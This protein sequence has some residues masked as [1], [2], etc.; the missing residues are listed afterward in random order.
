[1]RGKGRARRAALLAPYLGAI[2]VIDADGL[3]GEE[4]DFFGGEQF[5]QEQPALAI[6]MIDLRLS[7]FHGAFLRCFLFSLLMVRSASSRVSNHAGPDFAGGHPSRRGLRR[8][9][10]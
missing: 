5:G 2:G 10:G 9:S 7:E 4:G 6:E 8:S 3:A 1:M